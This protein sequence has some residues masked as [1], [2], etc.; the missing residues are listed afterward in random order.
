MVAKAFDDQLQAG[1]LDTRSWGWFVG[2]GVVLALLGPFASANLLLAAIA[3]TYI[4]GAAMFAGGILMLVSAFRVRRWAWAAFWALSGLLYLAAA[5]TVLYDP[6]FAAR[7]IV[8][9]LV[10]SMGASGLVRITLAL[11]GRTHGWGWMLASGLISVAAAVLIALG[12]P[13]DAIWVLG[14]ILAVD[15]FFQGITLMGIGFALKRRR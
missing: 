1:W 7:L 12:W 14:F 9:M 5:V 2:I 15:L 6:L 4:V 11:R 10:I 3:A 13:T 8:L